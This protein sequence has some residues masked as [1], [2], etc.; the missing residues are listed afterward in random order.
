MDDITTALLGPTAEAAGL[1][2]EDVEEILRA[3]AEAD[4]R[5]VDVGGE[6]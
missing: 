1:S 5:W 3:E 6:G 4:A 2:M